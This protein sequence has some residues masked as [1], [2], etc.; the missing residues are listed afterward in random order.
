MDVGK[1]GILA[2]EDDVPGGGGG[3]KGDAESLAVPVFVQGIGI[4]HVLAPDQVDLAFFQG[5]DARLVVR[6]DLDHHTLDPGLFAPV[7]LIGLEHGVFVRDDLGQLVGPGAHIGCHAVLGGAVLHDLGRDDG[8]GAGHAQFR[9]HGPVGGFHE[10]AE[11]MGIGGIH[12]FQQMHHLQPG[13]AGAVLKDGVEVGLDGKRIAR[14][15]VGE[16]DPLADM[17]GVDLAVGGDI[18]A[19]GQ[20]GLVAVGRDVHQGLEEHFLGVHLTGIQVRIE[21]PDIPV[22][23]EIQGVVRGPGIKA[24]QQECPRQG[25]G[26]GQFAE[27]GMNGHAVRPS[28]WNRIL[29][30]FP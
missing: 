23:D 26:H 5:Q 17:E 7:G 25:Q 15:P 16:R 11:R 14:G 27:C 3:G 30:S 2:V 10:D 22:I 24:G 12:L 29:F 13:M 6:D 21:I 20:A 28:F 9:E 19:F 4:Q 1:Y 8:K 18:P